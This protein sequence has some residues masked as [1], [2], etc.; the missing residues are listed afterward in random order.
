MKGKNFIKAFQ[1]SNCHAHILNYIQQHTFNKTFLEAETPQVQLLFKSSK[2]LVEYMKRSTYCSQLETT[3]K[4][5]TK[6]I[7]KFI[8]LSCKT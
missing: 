6:T 8:N 3:L 2:S 5:E 4:Q 7:S 1:R